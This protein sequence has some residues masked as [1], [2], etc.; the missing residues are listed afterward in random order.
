M[1]RVAQEQARRAIALRKSKLNH[2]REGY[3]TMKLGGSAR[4]QVSNAQGC[5]LSHDLDLF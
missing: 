3:T 5:L 1:A 4:V 2:T